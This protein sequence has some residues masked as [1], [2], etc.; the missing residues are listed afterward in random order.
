MFELMGVM[1]Y[2][3]SDKVKVKITGKKDN[4]IVSK[5]MK[6]LTDKSSLAMIIRAINR[7]FKVKENDIHIPEH[8]KNTL[9]QKE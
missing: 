9:K 8:I 1:R 7:E 3:D 6:S 5:Y 2:L 4:I